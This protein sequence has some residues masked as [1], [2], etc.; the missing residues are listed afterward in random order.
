MPGQTKVATVGQVSLPV[1]TQTPASSSTAGQMMG[2]TCPMRT[3]IT[4]SAQGAVGSLPFPQSTSSGQTPLPPSSYVGQPPAGAHSVQFFSHRS[5]IDTLA[6][7]HGQSFGRSS[8]NC[9]FP[10]NDGRA[11]L[12][13]TAVSP[14]VPLTQS[15][16]AAYKPPVMALPPT[17]YLALCLPPRRSR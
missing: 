9:V 12:S 14:A 10:C 4:T 16:L 1:T 5:C 15:S 11:T 8:I 3:V 6:A 2:V 13:F 17:L 7:C